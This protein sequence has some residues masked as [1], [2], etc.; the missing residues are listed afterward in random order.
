MMVTYESDY[1]IMKNDKRNLDK[2]DIIDYCKSIAR[3]D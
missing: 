1:D 3:F 2:I